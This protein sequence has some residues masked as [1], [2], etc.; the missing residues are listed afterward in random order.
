MHPG[1][2]QLDKVQY[3]LFS[4]IIYFNMPNIIIWCILLD[5]QTTTMKQTVRFQEGPC[6]EKNPDQ[7]PNS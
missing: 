3:G 5:S 1:K 4:A 7:I 2:V 6:P